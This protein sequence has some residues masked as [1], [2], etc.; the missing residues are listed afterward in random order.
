MLGN[1]SMA[2]QPVAS[3]VVLS[4][5]ESESKYRIILQN[6]IHAYAEYDVNIN[7]PEIL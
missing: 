2:T 5:T 7:V 3:Q 4:S 1:Y 6:P